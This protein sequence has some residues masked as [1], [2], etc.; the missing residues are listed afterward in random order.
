MAESTYPTRRAEPRLVYPA[1][2]GAY[3]ALDAYAHLV[4]RLAAGLMFV[5]HGLMKFGFLGGPGLSGVAGFLGGQ[6]Y[7]PGAFWAPFLATLETVGGVLL[8]IGLFTRPVAALFF[9]QM[10][11]IVNFHWGNGFLFTNQGGGYEYPLMW[12][13]VIFYFLVRGGGPMSVDRAMGREV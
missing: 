8:A 6:G 7:W 12:L 3:T 2:G 1:L 10:L 11:F 5:P 13:A 9:I 4:L